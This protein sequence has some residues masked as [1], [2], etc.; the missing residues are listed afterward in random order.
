MSPLDRL[1]QTPREGKANRWNASDAQEAGVDIL[2]VQSGGMVSPITDEAVLEKLKAFSPAERS[3]LEAT[4]LKFIV[5][6]T[7]KWEDE[8]LV[9]KGLIPPPDATTDYK[10]LPHQCSGVPTMCA[11]LQKH[12]EGKLSLA[13]TRQIFN[14]WWKGAKLPAGAP[15]PPQRNTAGNCEVKRTADWIVK[16]ILPGHSVET[17]RLIEAGDK[18]DGDLFTRSQRAQAMRE[19]VALEREELSRD[20][21]KG[22]YQP[23][24]LY[25]QNILHVGTILNTAITQQVEKIITAKLLTAI[26]AWQLGGEKELEMKTQLTTAAQE[27]ADEIRGACGRALVESENK[28]T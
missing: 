11:L 4:Y 14:H 12:F 2:G 16:W 6:K 20:V 1:R 9:K 18:E 13:L 19:L 5:G 7:A 22:L 17:A 26:A 23:V 27:A 15:P 8:K 25:R 28:I 3:N 10:D 21:E 24:S